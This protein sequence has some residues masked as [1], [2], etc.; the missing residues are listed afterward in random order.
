[1]WLVQF[2]LEEL[3]V[4]HKRGGRQYECL[5]A[6][7]KRGILVGA[8]IGNFFITYYGMCTLLGVTAAVFLAQVLTKS[9]HLMFDDM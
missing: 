3:Q 6:N 2:V 5:S 9:F 1:M 4:W 7:L 8:E